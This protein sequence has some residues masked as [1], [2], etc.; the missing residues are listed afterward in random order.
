MV[1]K[2]SLIAAIEEQRAKFGH[3][4]VK[5]SFAGWNKT[6]QYYFPDRDEFYQVDFVNG[7]TKPCAEGK[8]ETADISYEMDTDTFIAIAQKKLTGMKAYQQ[9]KVKLKASLPD[10]LKLQK[11]DKL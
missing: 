4:S 11:I 2:E 9:K 10:M 6:M 5:K 7:E 8:A 1:D 3:E